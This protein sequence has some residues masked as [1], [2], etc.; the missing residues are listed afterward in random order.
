M[1]DLQVR[2]PIYGALGSAAP[3][4]GGLSGASRVMDS[5][6]RFADAALGGRLFSW[7]K[8]STVLNATSDT[9]VVGATA[10]PVI[11]VWNPYGSTVNLVILQATVVL[12]QAPGSAAITGAFMW[13]SSTT[14]SVIST[15]NTPYNRLTM[16]GGGSVAKAYDLAT[17]LTGLSSNLVVRGAAAIPTLAAL[18]GATPTPFAG[19]VGVENVDGARIVPP[20]GVLTIQH[21]TANATVLVAS[22]LLWEEL[23]I[24]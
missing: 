22:E 21:T 4:T 16:L 8:T 5:H 11:G 9:S 17:A 6:G 15:G 3:F 10:T 7:G 18:Q 13:M 19:N 14:N 2:G 12:A 24:V 23:P 20:G 1:S